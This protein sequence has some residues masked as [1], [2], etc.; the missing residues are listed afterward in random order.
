MGEKVRRE[1]YCQ[2][3]LSS[4]INYTITHFADHS[5]G[6]SHDAINR[7]LKEE[8]MKPS[9]LWEQVKG[10]I[11]LSKN[12]YII[13]DDTVLNKKHSHQIELVRKQWSGNEKKVIKGIGVVNCVYVNP[14]QKRF[15]IIDYRLYAPQ[16][17]GKS[18]LEHVKEML[19]NVVYHKQLSFKTVLMDT[20]YAT[21]KLMKQ[22]EQLDKLYY[23]PVKSNR[24]A[25]DSNGLHKH[26]AVKQL[27][28]SEQ[29]QKQGKLVHLKHFPKGHRLKLFRL[30]LSPQ[31]TDFLVTNDLSQDDAQVAQQVRNLSWKIEQFHR[32]AKQVTGIEGCQCRSGRIQRNHIACAMLVWLRLKQVAQLTQRTIYQVKFGLLSDYLVSQLQSPSISFVPA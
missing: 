9:L 18:K 17:D 31:R 25:D 22:I 10:E 15:W 23:C 30:V 2:F 26:Q 13:F 7:Y 19:L 12:G 20:W 29:E 16:E 3:L 4:Q 24:L 27:I 11:D 14:E 6:F 21:V 5:Q 1:D 8:K 28:W 32:E